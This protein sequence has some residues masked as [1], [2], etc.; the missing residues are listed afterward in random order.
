MERLSSAASS[1]LAL[2]RARRAAQDV[3]ELASSCK[4]QS[5]RDE[6]CSIAQKA[7]EVISQV[8]EKVG[9]CYYS[10][11]ISLRTEPP[12]CMH[13]TCSGALVHIPPLTPPITPA[14]AG[15]SASCSPVCCAAGGI[16]WWAL[17]A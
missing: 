2:E 1:S 16:C 11:S 17:C 15:G 13:A 10:D 8:E 3:K 12:A 9:A 5:L 4:T 14:V 6:G 7:Q